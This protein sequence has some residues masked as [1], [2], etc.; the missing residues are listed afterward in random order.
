VVRRLC[1]VLL[2][3]DSSKIILITLDDHLSQSYLH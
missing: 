2:S 3:Q 1:A